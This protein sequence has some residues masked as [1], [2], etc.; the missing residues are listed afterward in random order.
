MTITIN[1]DKSMVAADSI[2]LSELLAQND[3]KMPETVSVQLN[4]SFIASADFGHTTVTDGD[5]VDF[6]YFMGGG[7]L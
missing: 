4:G 1:G 2:T 6:L 5:E 7:S 3:V